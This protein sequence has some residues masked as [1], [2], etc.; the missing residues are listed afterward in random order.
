MPSFVLLP[1]SLAPFFSTASF[2]RA[3]QHAKAQA[4]FSLMATSAPD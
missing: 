1:G 3:L 2:G 4:C